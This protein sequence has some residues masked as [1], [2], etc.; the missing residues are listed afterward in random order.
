MSS[1]LI[2]ILTSIVF[3]LSASLFLQAQFEFG[4]KAGL[5]YDS[6]GEL[7]SESINNTINSDGSE[8]G[9]HVGFY[10]NLNLVVFYIRPEI[11]FTKINSSVENLNVGLSKLEIPVLLGYKILGPLSVFI[12]PSFQ[13]ILDK[14]VK[15]ISPTKIKDHLTVGA[16]IG[17]RLSL[18]RFG[19]DIRY[20]RGF[21]NNDLILIGINGINQGQINTRPDQVILSASYKF[22]SKSSDEN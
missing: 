4:I 1:R 9:Y 7:K 3:F 5:N 18:G 22:K 14:E 6:L 16:Q 8:T 2:K 20:E 17:T 21:T 15:G 11:Q 13:Y 19:L 10:G 12:G